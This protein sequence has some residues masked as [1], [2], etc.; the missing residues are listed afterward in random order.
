LEEEDD[1]WLRPHISIAWKKGFDA[2]TD[3]E[4]LVL[5]HA[6]WRCAPILHVEAG[7]NELDQYEVTIM[8]M[9]PSFCSSH[10]HLDQNKFLLSSYY[11]KKYLHFLCESTQPKVIPSRF[12]DL[13][14]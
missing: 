8:G 6:A 2:R 11:I 4:I 7:P 12:E 13:D 10:P 5:D 3:R 14:L 1:N 9:Q